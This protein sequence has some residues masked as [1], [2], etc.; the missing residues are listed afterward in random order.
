LARA[1]SRWGGRTDTETVC[2]DTGVKVGAGGA[3]TVLSDP[4]DEWDEMKL[5][6]A[7]LLSC[8]NAVASSRAV[9]SVGAQGVE[10]VTAC[11]AG[12]GALDD[13]ASAGML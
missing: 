13:D 7:A 4:Q 10:F 9:E 3:I 1:S 12:T 5:K 6:A 8:A 2:A 11:S